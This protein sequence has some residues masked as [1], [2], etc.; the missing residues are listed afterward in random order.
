MLDGQKVSFSLRCGTNRVIGNFFA[1]SGIG[2]LPPENT[3]P[4][5]ALRLISFKRLQPGNKCALMYQ[6][7][8]QS[9]EI[10]PTQEALILWQGE[11]SVPT[12]QK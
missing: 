5:E 11:Q 3:P 12:A 4:K 10:R 8:L 7:R 6:A 1:I 2:V 9:L